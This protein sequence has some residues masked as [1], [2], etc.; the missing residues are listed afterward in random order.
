[1]LSPSLA[2]IRTEAAAPFG[3]TDKIVIIDSDKQEI[4]T[5]LYFHSTIGFGFSFGFAIS[6]SGC[7]LIW[8]HRQDDSFR[9]ILYFILVFLILFQFRFMDGRRNGYSASRQSEG[10]TTRTKNFIDKDDE[11][12][13]KNDIRNKLEKLELTYTEFDK[14]D[15]A[16]PIESSEMEELET[17]YYET[18]AKLQNILENLSVRNKCI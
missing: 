6:I 1:M 3:G 4:S 11:T 2:V 15:A 7:F 14:A 5:I 18:K 13:D 9:S 12:F 8:R 10:C 17:K 16:L